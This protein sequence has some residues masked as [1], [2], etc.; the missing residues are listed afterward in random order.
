MMWL[1]LTI[2]GMS[3]CV[4]VCLC[5]RCAQHIVDIESFPYVSVAFPQLSKHGAYHPDEVYTPEAIKQVVRYAKAH[6]IRV[7]TYVP[8]ACI[9]CLHFLPACLPARLPARPPARPPGL[10]DLLD[11]PD[12]RV[13]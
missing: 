9:A 12:L 13:I 7:H 5:V 6:G 8:A 4:C 2:Y 11:L 3:G 1:L 10:L